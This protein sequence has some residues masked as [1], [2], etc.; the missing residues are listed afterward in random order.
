MYSETACSFRAAFM[1]DCLSSAGVEPTLATR[2]GRRVRT[3]RSRV[4]CQLQ[5]AVQQRGFPEIV[6]YLLKATAR[7]S[8]RFSEVSKLTGSL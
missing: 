1:F 3:P 2:S 4:R 5:R 6:D 7:K 8:Q